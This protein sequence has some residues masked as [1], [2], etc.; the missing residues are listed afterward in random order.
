MGTC[1]RE[2]DDGIIS[3]FELEDGLDGADIDFF[4]GLD[5]VRG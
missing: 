3:V 4:D 1:R 2:V 5:L